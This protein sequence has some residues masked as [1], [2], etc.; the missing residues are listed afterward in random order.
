M[1]TI[2]VIENKISAVK[3]YI[4]GKIDYAVVGDIMRTGLRDIEKF[5]AEISRS[6]R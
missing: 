1:T 6:I 3:K 5:L 4:Y 2:A